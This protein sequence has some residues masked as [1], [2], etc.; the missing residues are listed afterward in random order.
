M[1]IEGCV[2]MA[3][4]NLLLRNRI[5]GCHRRIEIFTARKRSLRRLCFHRCLSVH[6]G[7][8]YLGRT[9]GKVHPLGRYTHRAG[10][11]PRQVQT[12]PG[13]VHPPGQLHPQ[14]GTP[15][16]RYTPQ[17]GTPPGRYT[18]SHHSSCW[19]TVNKRAVRIPL[20]CILVL[21]CGAKTDARNGQVLNFRRFRY[22]APPRGRHG[23]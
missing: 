5:Q 14:A 23:L 6:G 17:A 22:P 9:P 8:G 18:P 21:S 19:D 7:G 10:T 13:Q 15:L 12:P 4:E 3:K 1:C 2:A 20:E 11:P 16:G